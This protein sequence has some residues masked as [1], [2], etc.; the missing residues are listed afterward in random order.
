MG[1]RVEAYCPLARGTYL[2]DGLIVE[3]AKKHKATPAQILLRWSLQRDFI[4]LPK[5]D[6]SER[7]KE[8]AGVYHFSLAPADMGI[9]DGMDKGQK[10]AIVPQYTECP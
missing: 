4:P 9:I 6:S 3:L 2:N 1:I 7:I 8:N 5:S 10:G